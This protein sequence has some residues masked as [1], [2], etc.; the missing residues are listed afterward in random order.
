MKFFIPLLFIALLFANCKKEPLLTFS[1][2]SFSEKNLE[3]CKNEA[4][5]TVVVDYVTAVGAIEISEKINA[6][7]KQHIIEALFLGDDL[8]PSAKDIPQAVT[9]FIL[10]YRDHQPDIPSELDFGGYDAEITINNS[11]QNKE[12]VCLEV[13]QYLFTGGAHGYG[14][15][16]FISFDVATGEEIKIKDLF[17]AYSEFEAFAETKFKEAHNISLENN[18]NSTGLW[19]KDNT[20]YLPESIGF[21][22]KNFV[23][24]YNQYEIASYAAGQILLEIPLNEV[25]P[26]LDTPYQ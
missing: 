25:I 18:I 12:I 22:D 5:S 16:T 23:V 1:S 11:Y 9:D 24:F 26:F 20:F 10:A 21:D 14:G 19:F 8:T 7:I 15:S 17:V 6:K 3:I 4:C 13:H 2:E